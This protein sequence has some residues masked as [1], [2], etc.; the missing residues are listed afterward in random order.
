MVLESLTS[1]SATVLESLT[2]EL[3]VVAQVSAGAEIS[4]VAYVAWAAF[5][6]ADVDSD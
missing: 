5:P 2:L 1:A 3:D 6:A 4:S